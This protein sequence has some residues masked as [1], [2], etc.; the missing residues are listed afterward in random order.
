MKA[1]VTGAVLLAHLAIA[2]C[3]RQHAPM[4]PGFDA[5]TQ[6]T[7]APPRVVGGVPVSEVDYEKFVSWGAD[8]FRYETFGGERTTTDVV[9]LLNAPIQ[10]P[11]AHE[12]GREPGCYRQKST[13]AYFARALDELDGVPGNLYVGNGGP[14]GPGVTHDLTIR[15]PPGSRM[16]GLP[17]PEAVHTGLDVEAGSAWPIGISPIA[18]TGD[19]A[20]LPYLWDLAALG[21]GPVEG[22]RKVRVGITCALCHYSLD[23][24]WDGKIDLNSAR[25]GQPTKGSPYRP[26]H[27]WGVGNQDL[28]V[29]W[30]FAMSANP[31][32]G[33]SILSG[34]LGKN[35]PD[36]AYAWVEW[37]KNNYR[38][39]PEMVARE[40]VRG[41]LL[42][43]RGYAD[44][45]SNARY[46]AS[47]FPPLYTQRYWPSNSD[48]AVLNGTDRNSVVWTSTIDF[49]GLVSLAR[50]R[51]GSGSGLLYWE[52]KSIYD[53][54]SARELAD[55]MVYLS[56][57]GL[58]DPA[59]R[60]TLRDDILGESD[61]VPGLLDPDSIFVMEGPNQPIPQRILH[62]P[63]N[64]KRHR[65]RRAEDF[66]G[67]AAQRGPTLALLGMRVHTRPRVAETIGL[68]ELLSRYPKMNGDD[69][70]GEAVNAV[71]DWQPSPP[72]LSARL[73]RARGLVGKG[74]QVFKA[75]GCDACHRGPFYTDNLIHRVSARRAV[76]I[77]IA[78]PS[79]SPWRSLG[80][81][82]GTGIESDPGRTFD[83]RK[84]T[85]YVAPSYDPS[86]GKA[87][88][89]GSPLRGF[90]GNQVIGY[91]TTHLRYLW[92]S[93]PY[94]HDGGVGIAISPDSAV[95]GED[96]ALVL[97]LRQSDKIYGMGRILAYEE[98]NP[99]RLVRADAALSLQGLLLRS[100]RARIV[101]QR[102]AP[103]I[104]V[105]GYGRSEN[106][107][108][109]PEFVSA[110]HLG[111]E[112]IGHDFYI[113]DVPGGERITA[114]IAFLLSIDDDP[115]DLPK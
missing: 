71:L 108:G 59:R 70:M 66:G 42:Q 38:Q 83:S 96:L 107:L 30:L 22:P 24:D 21:V 75:E 81:G 69:V 95:D 85:L 52:E 39:A 51:G 60:D 89:A 86:S 29:G 106:P 35:D 28:K 45:S 4:W 64:E 72:N 18:V 109:V 46:N 105:P 50:D 48:G 110:S 99:D 31:L 11:C 68:S 77:G 41:M 61:G 103:V 23:V 47:Q 8:W 79:T 20:N 54:F 14:D 112:G 12:S 91:K 56:P 27:A 40:V 93:P 10:V 17:L 100:E 37:V 101:E 74:Y 78:S 5:L 55:L 113:D 65:I 15:F 53:L 84:L 13:L 44:V 26:E 88:A 102:N 33:F 111:I 114:L 73:A 32:V 94:L 87:V 82:V 98:A 92:G 2:G 16:H 62:H 67:D 6:P 58:Y 43:P 76:E 49:S 7:P 97:R 9:G 34:P 115:G 36:T 25:L 90:F 104:P 80:R 1:C 19:D 57:A 63:E 3:Q